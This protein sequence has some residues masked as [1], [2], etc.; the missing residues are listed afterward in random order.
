M[1]DGRRG[2]TKDQRPKGLRVLLNGVCVQRRDGSGTP[3]QG[4][5]VWPGWCVKSKKAAETLV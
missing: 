4:C 3:G 1:E 5:G 2:M